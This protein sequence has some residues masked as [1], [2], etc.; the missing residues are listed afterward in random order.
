MKMES[1]KAG[2]SRAGLWGLPLILAYLIACNVG[3]T[4]YLAAKFAYHPALGASIAGIYPPWNWLVWVVRFGDNARQTFMWTEVGLCVAIGLGFIAYV[5]IIGFVSRSSKRHEGIHGTAH[6]ADHAEVQATGLLPAPGKSGAGVYVGGWTDEK[7]RLH[8]LRHN[9]PE[10]VAVIAP[11]RSGKGVSLIVPTLLSWPESAV[12]LDSKAELFN[13]TAGW[14]HTSA[15]NRIVKFDPAAAE[16]SAGFNPLDSV[17][18]GTLHEVGDV[19]NTVT[20]IVDPEGKGLVDHWAKIAHGFLTGVVLHELYKARSQNRTASLFD[21]G[22]ALSDPTNPIDA[23]YKEML[24]N[25]HLGPGQLHPT[26]ASAARDMLNRPEEERG[27]ALST[28]MSFLMLYRDPLVAANISRSD[29]RLDELMDAE[30]PVTLYLV[31]R[32][33]DKDRLKPLIRLMLNQIVRVLLR[34]ELTFE[35]GRPLP[36]HKHRLLMMLDEFPSYGKLDVFQEAMAYIA[37]YGIKAYVVM[38]DLPQLWNSYGRDETITSNCHV[39]VA[40]APNKIETAEWLS[41]MSGTTTIVKEDIS[42]SGA[43]FGAVLQNVSRSLH[44]VSRPLITPDEALRLRAPVK[45]GS[46]QITDAGDVLVFVAGHSPIY[47]TQSLFFL[48][49]TFTKRAAIAPPAPIAAPAS[50]P[51][52]TPAGPVTAPSSTPIAAPAAPQAPHAPSPRPTQAELPLQPRPAE[53]FQA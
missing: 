39:R 53:R 21:I 9:G 29:F 16:G 4:Q 42:T 35:N 26:V 49:P 19:Q 37:G 31:I 52:A 14:R 50:M 38:Q 15:G 45:D 17:R 13:Q 28:S 51:I 8:Y 33:E 10:H 36:P 32:A 7:G 30:K 6:W 1:V 25:E 48:D 12:V 18:V 44:E 3:A 11:T 43:R 24:D 41:K 47:G 22:N 2:S 34:P 27:S 5:L 20:I 46:D 23:Y 40:F